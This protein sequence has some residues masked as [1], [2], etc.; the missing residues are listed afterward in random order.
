M[1][2]FANEREAKEYLVGEIAQEAARQGRPLGDIERKMLY[3]S[4]SGWTLPNMA[5]VAETFEQ[6]FDSKRYERKVAGL[7]QSAREHGGKDGAAAWSEAVKRLEPGDHYLLVM[8]GPAGKRRSGEMTWRTTVAVILVIVGLG[9]IRPLV[10]ERFLGHSPT[11]DDTVFFTWVALV[12]LTG[13]YVA[14]CFVVGRDRV[15][16]W[17]G[18]AIMWFARGKRR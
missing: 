4:E 1:S 7:A 9:V 5:E 14:L 16:G 13:I 12:V 17:L 15:E 2:R 10:L 18:Q 11:K 6:Q 3:F 8:V